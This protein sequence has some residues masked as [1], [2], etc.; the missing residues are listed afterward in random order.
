MQLLLQPTG[1]VSPCCWNQEI[2]YGSVKDKKLIDLWN[3]ETAQALRNEFIRGEP[4]LCETQIRHIK[5]NKLSVREFLGDLQISEIQSIGP[6]RLDVRLN[7]K[8]NLQCV[9]CDVWQQPNGLY[10]ESD[11]WKVGPKEIFPFLN[12][13][14]VLGGEPFVQADTYRLI[15]EIGKINP[16]CTWAF[17]TNANYKLTPFIQEKLDQI[18]IRWIQISLDSVRPDTYSKIR[19]NGDLQKTLKTLEDFLR[20]RRKRAWEGKPFILGASMCVQKLNWSEIANFISFCT[21]KKLDSILQFAYQP[22]EISLLSLPVS[23]RRVILDE[24][25]VISKRFGDSIISPILAP[26]KE[27]IT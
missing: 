17:V 3:S 7:G 8:C 18:Q 1:Y 20:Y 11:F 9:M 5:C 21:E 19:V 13:I 22:T 14:D 4:K 24:L 12:E 26:I 6:R 2:V 23:E 16:K 15:S 10:D 27:S 25:N